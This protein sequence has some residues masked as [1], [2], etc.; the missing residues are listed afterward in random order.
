MVC[1]KW[2]WFR[3][4]CGQLLW[5]KHLH[6]NEYKTG[7]YIEHANYCIKQKTVK[8]FVSDD[9]VFFRTQFNHLKSSKTKPTTS[10]R[11]NNSSNVESDEMSRCTLANVRK[12]VGCIFINCVLRQGAQ[13]LDGILLWSAVCLYSGHI[14]VY[15]NFGLF[16]NNSV[17]I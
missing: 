12:G 9:E 4:F 2:V 14:F 3:F 16:G 17:I 10:W 15:E 6:K 11:I 7:T 5:F 1:K 8:H 13:P